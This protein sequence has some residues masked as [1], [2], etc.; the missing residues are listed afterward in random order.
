M[1]EEKKE[2]KPESSEHISIKVQGQDGVTVQ[3][4]IKKTTPL[5][6]LMNTFAERQ[7]LNINSIRFMFEGSRI[8][9]NDTP[10]SLEMEEDDQIEVYT[11]QTGGVLCQQ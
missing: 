11:E 10:A 3:F 6:K 8:N 4:K 2:V 9:N 7:G 1:S 5:K